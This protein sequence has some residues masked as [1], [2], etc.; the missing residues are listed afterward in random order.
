[1]SQWS[2][3][4]TENTDYIS[5]KP[6][7][8]RQLSLPFDSVRVIGPDFVFYLDETMV[9]SICRKVFNQHQ[10]DFFEAISEPV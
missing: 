3:R 10:Q 9:C 2:K 1:M 4:I 6:A 5:R 8:K 7:I